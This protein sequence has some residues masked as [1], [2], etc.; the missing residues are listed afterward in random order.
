G[1]RVAVATQEP[2]FLNLWTFHRSGSVLLQDVRHRAAGNVT[3]AQ[4]VRRAE[5]WRPWRAYAA[6]H[7]WRSA[8]A[9][10]P[11]AKAA[12]PPSVPSSKR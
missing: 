1:N 2:G 9:M 11:A 5:A 10:S 7:L 3:A 8:S 12:T 4:L 6:M